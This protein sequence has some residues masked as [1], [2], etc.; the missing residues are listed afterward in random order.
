MH[1]FR[2]KAKQ[3]CKPD[4]RPSVRLVLY[5]ACG[6]LLTAAVGFSVLA[7]LFTGGDSAFANRS[8]WAYAPWLV[9]VVLTGAG[10]VATIADDRATAVGLIVAAT[11]GFIVT[12]AVWT[13]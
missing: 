11:A 3:S 13:V 8:G 2:M 10:C 9:A 4:V 12:Y 7:L 1:A 5:L 6:G